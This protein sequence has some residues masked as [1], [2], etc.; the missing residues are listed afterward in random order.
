MSEQERLF[1]VIDGMENELCA[2]SDHIFDHPEVAMHEFESMEILAERLESAGFDV[3][4]GVGGLETSFKAV[5][6]R[7]N[8]GP[9]LGLLCEYD[10]LPGMGH[11]CAHHM[12][13]PTILGAA[14]AL[15]ESASKNPFTVTVYGTP[16][17]ESVGG[18]IIMLKN[19][20]FS[21]LDVALMVHGAPNTSVDLKSM[22]LSSFKVRFRGRSTHAAMS[23]DEGRSALDGL[24]LMFNGIEFL[25]EHVRE[26][27]RIHYTVTDA[28]GPDNVVPAYAEGTVTLRSY[29]RVYL[30][31]V[32]DRFKDIVKGAELMTG[33]E[34]T[35]DPDLPF[36][37]KIPVLAL[38]EILM[39]KAKE[40]GAPSI[41]PP[42]ERTGSTDF[43]NVM[44][45]I[46][47]SCLRISFV[48][49]GTVAHSTEYLDAGKGPEIHRAI[50]MAAKIISASCL[51]LI[52]KPSCLKG[53][54]VEFR[55]KKLSLG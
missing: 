33:T 16:A 18:K 1:A 15:K 22:A 37:S 6:T 45:R 31:S 38:N 54:A 27:T 52:E 29:N 21:E 28:G 35:I 44:F 47:G 4:R 36:D 11:G 12:Q 32:V 20:C 40:L 51:E 7:G 43:G 24:L 14:L 9:N 26:D 48:S 19:G 46:P 42:R 55:D 39:D 10:A 34:G 17:E 8:G 41:A 2:M 3:E 25:R 13:G 50:V 49:E 23:P 5:Y 30:D 53:I